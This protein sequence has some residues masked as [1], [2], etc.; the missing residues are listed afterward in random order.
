MVLD[1]PAPVCRARNTQRDRP[2][3][4]AVL[5]T[6]LRRMRTVVGELEAEGWDLVHVVTDTADA[7]TTTHDR[8]G[9]AVRADG[10]SRACSSS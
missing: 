1:T 2:V 6:Q 8:R 4:A 9:T 5:T 10:C 3:P 7:R